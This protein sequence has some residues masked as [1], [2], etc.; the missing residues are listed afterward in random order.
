MNQSGQSK[1]RAGGRSPPPHILSDPTRT[2]RIECTQYLP[3][4]WPLRQ[5]EAAVEHNDVI[6]T[7]GLHTT[8]HVAHTPI[9]HVS[10][11]RLVYP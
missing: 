4:D 2:S 10:L 3:L 8:G 7:L 9:S 5:S 6:L 11:G 1:S